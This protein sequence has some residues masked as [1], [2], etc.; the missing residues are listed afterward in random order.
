[1]ENFK[2]EMKQRD[3]NEA[4]TTLIKIKAA[5][6]LTKANDLSCEINIAGMV[7]GLSDNSTIIPALKQ[8]AQEI[9]NYLKGKPNKYY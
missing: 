4:R 6:E 9:R 7:I 1:M 5:I 8:E 3:I 2:E